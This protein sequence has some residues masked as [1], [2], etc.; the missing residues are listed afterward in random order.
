MLGLLILH[1][2]LHLED[3]FLS[4]DGIQIFTPKISHTSTAQVNAVKF[5]SKKVK[6]T[7]ST[8]NMEF[9]AKHHNSLFLFGPGPR[10]PERQTGKQKHT[11]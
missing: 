6:N 8:Q 2:T 10:V 1:P 4:V 9:L 5:A 3:M 7:K 11:F